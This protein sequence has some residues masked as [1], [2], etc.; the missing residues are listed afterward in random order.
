M[1]KIKKDLTNKLFPVSL[2]QKRGGNKKQT[3][4][5]QQTKQ[6]NE[7]F[8]INFLIDNNYLDV[9]NRFHSHLILH[10]GKQNKTVACS[11]INSN[12][13]PYPYFGGSWRLSNIGIN[14]FDSG[15]LIEDGD[16]YFSGLLAGINAINSGV[17]PA[18][19]VRECVFSNNVYGIYLNGF[20]GS[21]ILG[22]EFDLSYMDA[23]GVTTYNSTGYKIEENTFSNLN[24]GTTQSVGVLINESG[25]AENEIY[26]NF[27]HDLNI[28]IQALGVNSNQPNSIPEGLQFICNEFY[29]TLQT[30]ILVGASPT[31]PFNS[32]IRRDQGA[33]LVSA[34][35]KF[36]DPPGK[37]I[38]YSD[39]SIFY[40]YN[41]SDPLEEV[42]P[43]MPLP[44]TGSYVMPIGFAGSNGCPPR[45][46]DKTLEQYDLWNSEYEYWLALL[47]GFEG[48]NEEEYNMILSNVAYFG[49]LKNNYFNKIIAEALNKEPTE[50]EIDD[51]G[52][53]FKNLRY[54]FE[55][56]GSY[57]DYLGITETYLAEKNYDDALLTLANMY[58]LF[59]LNETQISELKGLDTYVSWRRK[60]DSE[61]SSIFKLSPKEVDDLVKYVETNTGRGTVFANNILCALYGICIEE[62]APVYST[63]NQKSSLQ[64]DNK[65]LLDKIS[66]IPNPTTGELRITNYELRIDEIEIFDIM[67]K[68]VTL[69]HPIN[70]YSNP[71]IDISHLNSGI[72]FVKIV[73]EQGITVKKVVKQ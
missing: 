41:S 27:F 2:I 10:N 39:F 34:G 8:K 46:H 19:E 63:P 68:Q 60:L 11:F 45:S 23:I 4:N 20:I 52:L 22:N 31:P 6:R 59:E 55:Y 36:I 44:G 50:E 37:I 61:G 56:R 16:T 29:Y 64:T 48:D 72:Y 14:I 40:F 57:T 13:L 53:K 24:I 65:A 30:D 9:L 43:F 73:T 32:S 15:L 18:F 12:P 66:V 42:A 7:A 26:K 28:G 17:S 54:L 62:K 35:N 33:L 3:P 51:P 71:K 5:T 25:E 49:G 70:S 47:H 69:N 58:Q 1:K 67:G 21:R 38:N